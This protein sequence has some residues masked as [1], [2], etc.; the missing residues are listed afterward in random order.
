[1][2]DAPNLPELTPD[3]KRHR[4][5]AKLKKKYDRQ[6]KRYT[7]YE[8][9]TITSLMDAFTIILLFLLKSFGADPVNIQQSDVLKLAMSSSEIKVEPAVQIALTAANILVNDENVVELVDR[10]VEARYKKDGESGYFINPLYERLLEEAQK[11]KHIASLN[12]SKPFEGYILVA[13][14]KDTPFRLLTEVMYTAGQAEFSKFMFA[15]V[16]T[17]VSGGI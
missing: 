6:R 10:K 14:D 5:W 8:E 17:S 13:A 3:Q 9:L 7:K 2:S 12:P 11:E 1:M 15:V 16:S 4:E